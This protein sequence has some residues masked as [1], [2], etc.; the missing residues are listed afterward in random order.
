MEAQ[1]ARAKFLAFKKK[2]EEQGV[3]FIQTDPRPGMVTIATQDMATGKVISVTS[4]SLE[5]IK[6]EKKAND[7]ADALIR[8]EEE[9][10]KRAMKKGKA[11]QPAKKK[12]KPGK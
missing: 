2:M 12:K 5:D 7:M 10:K 6:T 4:E 11:N 3:T 9:D 1:D 8:E